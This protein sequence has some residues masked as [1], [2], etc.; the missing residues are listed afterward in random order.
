MR[1]IPKDIARVKGLGRE[2]R[3]L[4]PYLLAAL[5]AVP[6][7]NPLAPAAKQVVETWDGNAIANA[8][9][10]TQAQAG[11][12]IFSTWLSQMIQA[13]FADELGSKVGEASSNMLIHVLDDALGGGSAVPASRDYFNGVNPNVVMSGVFDATVAALAAAQ[14]PNPATWTAPRGTTRFNHPLLG[15]VATIPESNR[16]TYAQIVVARRPH[17]T[18]ENIFTLGQSGF[19]ELVPPAGFAFDPFFFDLL[20]LYRNFEYKP[21]HLFQNTQLTE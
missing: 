5:A 2:A 16:A 8:I 1:D 20:G 10:S 3:F 9:T 7:A 12:L 6:P 21:M 13:T 19:V 11:E 17:M 15:T 4:R 14:G 18:G